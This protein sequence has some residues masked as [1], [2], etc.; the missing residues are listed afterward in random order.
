MSVKRQNCHFM[1]LSNRGAGVGSTGRDRASF[2]EELVNGTRQRHSIPGHRRL[3]LS[4]GPAQ[5][6]ASL[7]WFMEVVAM[8]G[9]SGSPTGTKTVGEPGARQLAHA[10]LGLR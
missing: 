1:I 3:E 8:H 6:Y 4:S 9:L 5:V 2:S 7:G 10:G